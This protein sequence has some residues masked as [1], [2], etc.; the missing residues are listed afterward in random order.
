MEIGGV[1]LGHINAANAGKLDLEYKEAKKSRTS[2]SQTTSAAQAGI[3]AKGKA[4]A[5]A[6]MPKL[7]QKDYDWMKKKAAQTSGNAGSEGQPKAPTSGK[8]E[9]DEKLW[10]IECVINYRTKP[11]TRAVPGMAVVYIPALKDSLEVCRASHAQCKR[12]LNKH[13][14]EGMVRTIM[15]QIPWALETVTMDYG[16]NP[17]D[18]EL[19]GLAKEWASATTE[20]KRI[21][22]PEMTE[23]VIE[24]ES[25]FSQPCWVRVLK[26]YFEMA[27]GYSDRRKGLIVNQSASTTAS[28]KLREMSNNL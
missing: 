18:L 20:Q 27:K 12:I 10:H 21:L 9:L 1:R 13:G 5:A 23:L 19:R 28:D 7:T 14:A 22:E 4:K 3:D 26:K 15:S 24:W 2:A 6:A 11:E 17:M 25:T 8:K 16:Y